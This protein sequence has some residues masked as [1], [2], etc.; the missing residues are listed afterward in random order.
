LGREPKNIFFFV[1]LNNNNKKKESFDFENLIGSTSIFI[2]FYLSSLPSILVFDL[3][4]RKKKHK[5]GKLIPTL[6]SFILME[7]MKEA[8][9]AFQLNSII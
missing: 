8:R 1:F 3:E 5:T 9:M 4:K 2:F 7:L 6:Y